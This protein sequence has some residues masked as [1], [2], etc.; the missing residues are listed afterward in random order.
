MRVALGEARRAARRGEVPIGAV[1]VSGGRVVAR[2]FNRPLGTLDPTA[3]AEISALRKAGRKIG[4]YR[5]TDCDLYVTLEPCPMCLGAVVHARLRRLVYGAPDPKT[6][7]VRSMMRF[8][9]RRMNH[10]PEIRGGV[11]AE[12]CGGILQAFFREKR[13]S[14]RERRAPRRTR[15]RVGCADQSG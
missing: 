13:A 3:H 6:G 7:A 15:G 10:R 1:V 12:A 2:G 8:P 4:N 11:L 5:L 9:F 14:A